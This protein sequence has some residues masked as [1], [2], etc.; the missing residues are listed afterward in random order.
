VR[1]RFTRSAIAALGA[2][3]A[4]A[5]AIFA[6]LVATD[7]AKWPAW[8][9]PFQPWGWWIVLGLLLAAAIVAAWEIVHRPEEGEDE[10]PST[11][12]IAI[13]NAPTPTRDMQWPTPDQTISNLPAR[14]PLFTG[15]DRLLASLSQQLTARGAVTATQAKA[16]HGLGGIGK[17]Q[18]VLEYAYRHAGD[19]DL[20]WWI[21]AD[22]SAAIPE[23]L[24]ALARRLGIPE[25]SSQAETVATLLDELR[26]HN[27]WLLVFDNA[28][29]PRELHRFWPP[30]GGGHI[31]IT[32]RNSSWTGLAA[33]IPVEVLTRPEAIE[34]LRQRARLAG[35][36]A[37]ALAEALGDLPLALE[38]A[39]A[40]MDE[41][42]TAPGEYLDMLRNR[43]REL[44][45]LGRPATSEQTI[46]TVWEVSL[47]RIRMT[48]PSAEDLL[49]FCASFGPD[50]L[51]RRLVQDYSLVLPKPLAALV[52][53]KLAFQQ[54]VGALRRYSLI[55]VT[56]DAFSMHRL[57]QVVVR[58]KLE[59][60][61]QN[62]WAVTAARVLL[63][64]LPEDVHD[65]DAW[66]WAARLLPHVIS[67]TASQDVEESAPVVT[68]RLLNRVSMYLTARSELDLARDLAERSLRIAE[69]E[70]SVNHLDT[71]ASL[72]SLA[73][74]LHAQ[75]NPSRA[76]SLHERALAIR[77]TLLGTTHLD[78]GLSL[79]DLALV[80]E[81][82]GEL[83]T[84]QR[85]QERALEI[86]EMHRGAMHPHTAASLNNLANILQKQGDLDRART[87]HE[88]ALG[89]RE[90]NFGQNHPY[91]AQSLHSLAAISAAEGNLA[92]AQSLL[93]RALIAYETQV[94]RDSL[95]SA[96]TLHNLALIMAAQGNVTAAQATLERALTIYE[97]RLGHDHPDTIGTRENL[98][99]VKAALENQGSIEL[100]LHDS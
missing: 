37:E 31:L 17:T 30:A 51:P 95:D 46:A 53:D 33:T 76:R 70:S 66:P 68:V 97:T 22:E 56:A 2:L 88:R 10:S 87:L 12:A 44:L 80:L 18:L 69:A 92:R 83:D 27:R 25:E 42:S 98:E 11:T 75:G 35:Q 59:P 32:S 20:M 64:A 5:L 23:Q 34:F 58:G 48:I 9:R 21:G 93:E 65:F 26:H 73:L 41:T 57:V 14:N 94:G 77:E 43:G 55:T 52:Q 36:A 28:D 99:A 74:V 16:I 47:R 38:Q 3:T 89:I 24:V 81:D 91:I 100:Q 71:A 49:T 90:A 7:P 1:G 84:A 61:Q 96:L 85:L 78:T 86:R 15:R 45:A 62:Q 13:A 82:Q 63:E 8:A 29:E 40:Y 4:G 6:T 67:A 19:Y 39:S 54:A 79:N 50:D 72:Y 60:E